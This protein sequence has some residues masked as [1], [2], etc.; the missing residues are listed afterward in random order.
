MGNYDIYKK[1][2]TF[3]VRA[4]NVNVTCYTDL[5][6]RA[7]KQIADAH[8]AIIRSVSYYSDVRNF[9]VKPTTQCL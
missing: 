8:Y 5:Y 6:K 4:V 2:Q 9:Y 1:S 7:R 3:K